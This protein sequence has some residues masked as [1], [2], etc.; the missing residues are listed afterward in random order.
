VAIRTYRDLDVYKAS[1]EA[2]LAVSKLSRRFPQIEQAE[3]ARQLRRSAR[4][5]PANI[6]EGWAKRNSP[7][8]FK[9]YLQMAVGSCHETRVWLDMSRDEGYITEKEHQDLAAR[10]NHIGIMLHKLWKGWRPKAA[11]SEAGSAVMTSRPHDLMTP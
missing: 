1:Y 11:A 9:R 4:S 5:V 3:L 8:E 7:Q 10:Y 2:A 6:A